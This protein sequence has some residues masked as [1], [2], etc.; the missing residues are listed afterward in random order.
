MLPL[1]R[2]ELFR[3][4]RRLMPK[5]L[6]LIIAGLPVLLYLLLWSVTSNSNAS[7]ANNAQNIADLRDSLRIGAVRNFG[8]GLV[9]Q[10]G[11]VLVVILSASQI[12]SEY[13]WGTLRTLIPRTTSRSNFLAA[14]LATLVLFIIATVLVGFV[15]SL[16]VSGIITTAAGLDGGLGTNPVLHTLASLGRTMYVMLPFMALAFAVSLW[17]RSTGA[18]IGIGLAV[19]FLEAIITSL[20]D[21]AGGVFKKIPEALLNANVQGVLQANQAGLHVGNTRRNAADIPNPWQAAG[22]LAVYTLVFLAI[23]FWRFRSRDITSG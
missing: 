10:F 14:K 5:I 1:L 11:T 17:S 7:R 8:L 19:L 13:G 9:Y 6:L 2:S 16:L 4:S 22:V 3:L 23:A 15:A 18:G 12:A 21:N 20:I